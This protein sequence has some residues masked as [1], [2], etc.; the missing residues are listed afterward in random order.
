MQHVFVG[1]AIDDPAAVKRFV[2]TVCE[3]YRLPYFTVT[4]T[5]SVCPEHGYA[6]GEHPRCP[7]CGAPAEVYSRV[8]GYLRPVQQWNPG[9]QAEFEGRRSLRLGEGAAVGG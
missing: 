9:K 6:A 3:R 5:F 2:R 4:P 7:R 8:V 1:E